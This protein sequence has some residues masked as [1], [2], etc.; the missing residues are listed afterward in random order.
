MSEKR[1]MSKRTIRIGRK[2]SEWRTSAWECGLDSSGVPIT[3]RDG[4]VRGWYG[5]CDEY[6]L[7]NEIMPKLAEWVNQG[8]S[9]PFLITQHRL[10]SKTRVD[11]VSPM[12]HQ[13][14]VLKDV[15]FRKRK[16]QTEQIHFALVL[17]P[18]EFKLLLPR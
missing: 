18:T 12:D 11:I 2:Y 3:K 16:R 9:Y 4:Y 14:A 15:R 1:E 7:Q 8:R 17:S 13:K 6:R 10:E 5:L